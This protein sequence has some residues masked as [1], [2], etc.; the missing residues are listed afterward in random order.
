MTRLRPAR[1]RARLGGA[2]AL[3]S[4]ALSMVVAGCTSP[5]TG[6]DTQTSVNRTPASTA[7]PSSSATPTTR[8]TTAV[9]DSLAPYAHTG[10][11]QLT[12]AAV[13][14]KRLVYVPNQVAGTLQIIDPATHRII[15]RVRVPSSPEHVVP[16][17]DMTRLWV[18]SDKGDALTPIDPATGA[19]GTPVHLRDPYNLY[20]TPDG[21]YALVMAE[22]F[23][24]IDVRDAH[25]MKLV[26]SLHV[27]TCAGVNHG[28]F[29]ADLKTFVASCEFSGRLLVVDSDATRLEKVI[30][31]NSVK[32]PGATPPGSGM[33]GPRS[34]LVMGASAM[35]QDVRLTPDGKWF[36]AADMLRNGV[37]F[38]DARTFEIDHFVP[39][40][41]GAH[42]IYPSRDARR[43]FVSNRDAG[44]ITVFDAA[45]DKP[46][47]TWKLPG[48]A[49]PDMGG[50]TADGSQLW[51]SGRYSSEVYVIDTT[52]GHL[53]DRIHTDAGPHGL[54]VWPQPGRFSLGHTGNM[55]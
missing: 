48:H 33:G 37:W 6:A 18:N 17:W 21:K 1:A 15:K 29:T 27:P 50:V 22:R 20:F 5:Q 40:A 34:G 4:V 47:S 35:P 53:I 46:M 13:H 9:A 16:N 38:I 26:R 51:L 54:L 45:T 30:D 14:A 42:G 28:D 43:V 32:T 44:S 3:V 2:A 24:S 25:T 52:D 7:G 8:S 12:G 39:T 49:T 10:A 11:D 41:M 23:R 31:L 55:R 36:M 19:V